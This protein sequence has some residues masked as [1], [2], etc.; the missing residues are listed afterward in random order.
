LGTQS[1]GR[2][3]LAVSTFGVR[4][5]A[6]GVEAVARSRALTLDVRP[7][8]CPPVDQSDTLANVSAPVRDSTT[9]ASSTAVRT[10]EGLLMIDDADK[11]VQ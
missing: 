5:K 8:T 9:T 7:F 3:A 2:F 6:L 4:I 1:E 11:L 10:V